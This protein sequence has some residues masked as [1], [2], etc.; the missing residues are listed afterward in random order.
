MTPVE[1]ALF[2][3]F[4]RIVP[5]IVL[6]VGACV[7]F[8]GSAARP[9]RRLWATVALL[10]LAAAGAT[11]ALTA[12]P[13]RTLETRQ[14]H[15]EEMPHLTDAQRL[16][17]DKKQ[18]E[19]D[20]AVYAA[21]LLHT[22][23]SLFVRWVAILGA[24]VLVL[25]GWEEATDRYAG[26]Y[27]ACLLLIAAGVALTGAANELVLLFL[28]L[29]LI[30]IPTY[31]LLYLP[32]QDDAAQEAA[33]KYFLLSVFSSGLLLFGFS[34]L[35]GLAG[36]T[37]LAA[38]SQ[39]VAVSGAEEVAQLP[40][41]ALVALVLVVAGLGFKVTAVPFHFYAPDVY[42]GTSFGGAALLAFVPKVAGFV[43][44]VLVLDLPVGRE[45]LLSVL[46]LG[47]KVSILLWILAAVTMTLGNVLA[48]WQNN[49]KRLLAYSSVAHAGYM[50]MGL[51]VASAPV[52]HSLRETAAAGPGGVESVL[53]YLV[54]YGAMTIGAFAVLSC[55]QTPQRP[56]ETVDDVA[57]L[58]RSH[59][60]L[61]LLLTLFLFS[62]I[63]IPLTAGF[64]GKYLLFFGAMGVPYELTGV[65]ESLRPQ[66]QLAYLFR[67]LALI[68]AVNAAVGGWYY[69]RIVA[70]MYLRN[71]VRPLP[72]VSAWPLRVAVAVCAVLTLAVG[73]YPN[74]LWQAARRTTHGAA[75][76]VTA[77]PA[78]P[79]NAAADA[80][81]PAP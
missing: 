23:L 56:V 72:P 4:K 8:L 76:A 62:L 37:N 28:A 47:G 43:A 30:S 50:L 36:T 40:G 21:P 41:I 81:R 60:G 14:F 80:S 69:L 13:H 65:P 26:E 1:N 73:V 39:A 78:A 32:R 48:L 79:E 55:L 54:A 53:F 42:Q 57:G 31:V 12:A 33:M 24:A 61:A 59:P 70:V 27:H 68:A 35:Y 66:L 17:R 22:R 20:A 16:E 15:L 75:G 77:A 9:G 7:L 18:R 10:I 58:S 2:D 45:S 11:L 44:L 38:I 51:A 25:V 6:L 67:V 34:Y 63:G 3:V 71:A 52:G 64:A 74:P 19:V 5:E 29:E 46:A 49:L